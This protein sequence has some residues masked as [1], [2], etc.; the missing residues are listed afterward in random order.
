MS[1]LGGR[2]RDVLNE[3]N[4]CG[5]F[6]DDGFNRKGISPFEI[7]RILEGLAHRGLVIRTQASDEA[8]PYTLYTPRVRHTEC[9]RCHMVTSKPDRKGFCV[10]CHPLEIVDAV[11]AAQTVATRIGNNFDVHRFINELKRRGYQV[12]DA[13]E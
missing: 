1:A 9:P 4:R 13:E 8:A 3:L 10:T 6:P 5:G 12:G 2:Q 7:K 11:A